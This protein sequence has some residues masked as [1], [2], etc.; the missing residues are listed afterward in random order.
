M[1]RCAATGRCTPTSSTTPSAPST[2]WRPHRDDQSFDLEQ[3]GLNGGTRPRC[4][5]TR[6]PTDRGRSCTATGTDRGCSTSSGRDG[7]RGSSCARLGPD[8]RRPSSAPCSRPS[9]R[10]ARALGALRLAS[11]VGGLDF[12]K[13]M[14]TPAPSWP[15]PLRRQRPGSCSPA[16]PA[17][18]DIPLDAPGSGLMGILMSMLGQ[19]SASRSRGRRRSAHPALARGCGPWAARS[20]A[21]SRWPHRSAGQRPAA[22][23]RRRRDGPRAARPSSP[24]SPPRTS[25][26]GCVGRTTCR[27][28]CSRAMQHFQ[29]DPST[30][31]VD[32]ALTDRCRGSLTPARRPGTVHIADSVDGDGRGAGAGGCGGVPVRPFLLAGQ[33]TTTDATRSPAGTESFWAYTHVPQR[34]R[35][36]DAGDG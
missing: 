32:W 28:G 10:C 26:A 29:L 5:G 34:H 18:A 36:R 21:R 35:A 8:R 22:S 12:V 20:A 9:R 31:K 15:R 25:T 24:T 16:T 1:E 3:H 7:E 23:H 30:V 4:W 17:H 2:R 11:R 27:R 19:T 14:L 6:C 33:M 13:H